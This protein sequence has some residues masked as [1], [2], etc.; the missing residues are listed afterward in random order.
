M[1]PTDHDCYNDLDNEGPHEEC[2][3][4]GASTP[5]GEG[6]GQ[7]AF[8][9]LFVASSDTLRLRPSRPRVELAILVLGAILFTTMMQGNAGPHYPWPLLRSFPSIDRSTCPRAGA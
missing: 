9:G 4:F 7:L 6:L 3:V 5:Q 2:G 1:F 8:F